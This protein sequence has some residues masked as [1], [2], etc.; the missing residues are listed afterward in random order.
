MS[1]MVIRFKIKYLNIYESYFK[2]KVEG[3]GEDYTIN[4]QSE[5]RGK[6]LKL[7]FSPNSKQERFLVRITGPGNIFIEDYLPYKGESEWAEI[8]SDAITFYIA[9]HQDQF[10]TLEI[11]TGNNQ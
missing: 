6:V 11:I 8:D 9:D 7:P 5:R 4:I 1:A 2:G 3:Y 10:D